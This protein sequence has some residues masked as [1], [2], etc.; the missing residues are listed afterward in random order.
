ML[1]P[2]TCARLPLCQTRSR[3]WELIVLD[4][5]MARIANAMIGHAL[6]FAGTGEVGVAEVLV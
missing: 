2:L 3:K 6:G 5:T 4:P 1:C